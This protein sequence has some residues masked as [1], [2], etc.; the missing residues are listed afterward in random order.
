MIECSQ[1][2]GLNNENARFCR[3][4]GSPLY[5]EEYSSTK[6]PLGTILDERYKIID[7]VAKGGMGAVYK[8]VDLEMMSV[9]AVKEML[10]YFDTEDEREYAVGRFAT[11][12][13]ILYD[14]DHPCIPKFVDC[15][16]SEN[17]YYLI[18]EFIDGEDLRTMLENALEE[19]KQGLEEEDVVNWAI[20]LC[21]VL[22]YLHTQDSP[23]IYRDMKPGNIMISRDNKVYLIDFGI[24]RLFDPRVKGTMV[25]TQGY[26]P[27][28]QYRGEAEPRSDMYSL[29]A[30]MHHILT[31]KDPRND[32]P[33]NFPPIR[34]LRHD[35]SEGLEQLLEKAL[36]MDPEDRFKDMAQMKEALLRVKDLAKLE[37]EVVP[38]PEYAAVEEISPPDIVEIVGQELPISMEPPVSTRQLGED[39]VYTGTSK[40]SFWYTFRSDRRHSGKSPFGKD[41]QGRLLWTFNTR[42][43]IRS[44][45]VL[46]NDGTIY[47][48]AHN[49]NLYA[50]SAQGKLRWIFPTRCRI[51][52]S[53]ALTR[54]SNIVV[55]SNDCHVYCIGPS[56]KQLWK[57]R[58]YGRIRSSPCIGI[59]GTIYVGSHDHYLYAINP[60]GRLKWRID[61]GGYLES[62]PAISEDGNIYV[63]SK[64]AFNGKSY[65]YCLDES[66]NIVWY[67]K[68]SGA[69]KSSPC[70]SKNDQL[71]IG[72]ADGY[73]YSFSRGGEMKWKFKSEGPIF[74]SALTDDESLVIFGSFDR[75]VYA[76]DPDGGLEWSY[77]TYSS[78]V[79]S[80]AMAGDGN[81]FVGSD[82][83]YIYAL[84]PGGETLWRIKCGGRVRSSPAV[85]E[86]G[87]LY[88][89]SDDGFLYAIE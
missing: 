53:P 20:Q 16:V 69:V 76:L 58:T 48:G 25:G 61:L 28:E 12:A 3:H 62:A 1:C 41:I 4:C 39:L 56:G 13:Q 77:Q 45:P 78:V 60:N 18:M 73:L 43:P 6:L 26:A 54:E 35:L 68:I 17:R 57:F 88:V 14:L 40:L 74:S 9:W 82:D 19:G 70:I 50:I 36:S 7:Y 37:K 75:N 86:K 59:D 23:I 38:A 65:I 8:A 21:D 67:S 66:G 63:A 81:T 29:A 47:F 89:G 24:A 52:S 49:G 51:L 33:F 32:I 30:C 27:P 72:G 79:S 10:D 5:D 55:G 80:P 44:S 71:Y 11:E 64:G 34:S 22:Q 46:G 15:F 87:V 2:S 31:G 42:S 84:S 85:G 83:Y